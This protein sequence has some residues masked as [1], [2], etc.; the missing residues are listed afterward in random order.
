MPANP[1][2]TSQACLRLKPPP[3]VLSSGGPRPVSG[4]LLPA[5]YAPRS[6]YKEHSLTTSCLR[7]TCPS[8]GTPL[9]F[10]KHIDSWTLG[11]PLCSFCFLRPTDLLVA[12]LSLIP[13]SSTQPHS[14][15]VPLWGT[16]AARATQFLDLMCSSGLSPHSD[17]TCCLSGTLT[18]AP[19][20]FPPPVPC[21]LP[22]L[23]THQPFTSSLPSS[24]HC[25]VPRSLPVHLLLF[26]PCHQQQ[27][28]LPLGDKDKSD[29]I[30]AHTPPPGRHAAVSGSHDFSLPL[31]TAEWAPTL[32]FSG[33][34]APC[35]KD[36]VLCVPLFL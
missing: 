12:A 36:S 8:R 20:T 22:L 14:S 9:L 2:L 30:L 17:Q 26:L 16:H 21:H 27:L 11:Q 29:H 25:S 10:L 1:I 28:A 6:P 35:P 18:I 15:L 13:G 32:Q 3:S 23:A 19:C 4:F 33:T 34:K 24:I 5:P 31:D 7:E